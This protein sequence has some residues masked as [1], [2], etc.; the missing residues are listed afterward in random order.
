MTVSHEIVFVIDDDPLVRKTV[1]HLLAESGCEV[2]SFASAEEYLNMRPRPV[3]GCLVLDLDLPGLD[4]LE[5]QRRVCEQKNSLP[6]VFITG[7]GDIPA[8]VRAM[9][10]GAVDFLTKPLSE[11]ALI[12]AVRL[13]L[14]RSHEEHA[15]EL[16]RAKLRELFAKLT[17]RETDVLR[18][19]VRGLLNKQVAAQLGIAEKTVKIHRGRLMKK[20]G[21]RSLVELARLAER[22]GISAPLSS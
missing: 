15:E 7:V 22:A 20:V 21:A 10:S 11:G 3:L 16:E 8:T 12:R 17:A 18:L 19:V 13:A 4:G 1:E 9:K 6:I 14:R 2:R 5:L